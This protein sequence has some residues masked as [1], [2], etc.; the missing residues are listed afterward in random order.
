MIFNLHT[1]YKKHEDDKNWRSNQRK[2]ASI[3]ACAR[4]IFLPTIHI[5][6]INSHSLTKKCKAKLPDERSANCI[7]WRI[8]TIFSSVRKV[9]VIW[10]KNRLRILLIS[11][12]YLYFYFFFSLL[13][14]TKICSFVSNYHRCIVKSF[15]LKALITSFEK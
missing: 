9:K 4:I 11:F 14:I 15:I 12:C 8:Q 13:K 5:I 7:S 1:A 6:L 3:I 2:I 10:M